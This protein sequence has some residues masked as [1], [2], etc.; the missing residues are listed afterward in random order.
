MAWFSEAKHHPISGRR[1]VIRG[2]ARW[3]GTPRVVIDASG[4][5]E[6]KATFDSYSEQGFVPH[7][8]L[9]P[10]EREVYQHLDYDLAAPVGAGPNGGNVRGNVLWVAIAKFNG[11]KLEGEDAVWVG[12]QIASLADAVGAKRN[13]VEFAEVVPASGLEMTLNEWDKWSGVC[14]AFAVPNVTRSGPGAMSQEDFNAGFVSQEVDLGVG[15]YLVAEEAKEDT[16]EPFVLPEFKGR[17]FGIGS[18]SK[19]VNDVAVWLGLP[20]KNGFDAEMEQR[21]VEIQEQ[22][23][24]EPTGFVDADTW[25]ALR[26][27][28]VEEEDE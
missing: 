12:E 7:I 22:F 24:L 18:T 15:D 9:F 20:I 26:L 16:S 23:G 25:E 21:V 11:E 27:S 14:P 28:V 8:T 5:P 17:G 6:K 4:T 2:M 3:E 13:L 10:E 1:S 19:K